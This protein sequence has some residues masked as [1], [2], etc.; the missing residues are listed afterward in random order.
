[1]LPGD[2]P[3][4]RP[5]L[6]AG[7]HHRGADAGVTDTGHQLLESRA[8]S[9]GQVFAGMAEI[10]KMQSGSAYHRHRG[11]PRHI[12]RSCRAQPGAVRP[13]NT[14]AQLPGPRTA[15]EPCAAPGASSTWDTDDP[16]SGPGFRRL[17]PKD[18]QLV[19]PAAES[20]G[21]DAHGPGAGRCSRRRSAVGLTPA[22]GSRRWRAAPGRGTA[23]HGGNRPG[24]HW[25]SS[26]GLVRPRPCWRTPP[27]TCASLR[28]AEAEPVAAAGLRTLRR[29]AADPLGQLEDLGDGEHRPFGCVS[30]QRRGSG[31]GCGRI[32][33][34]S[35]AAARTARS[36]R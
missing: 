9:G 35:T 7:T 15:P 33:S 31:T 4:P 11:R 24:R 23:G 28:P 1:M 8:G 22:S 6:R 17:R 12:G 16:A 26:T 3:I 27:V 19:R 30:S 34:S 13:E 32:L 2:D 21:A 18:R 14:S 5:A 25:P 36:S 29:T 10:M 20:S